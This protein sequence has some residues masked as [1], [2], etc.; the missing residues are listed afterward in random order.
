MAIL[1]V[2]SL[3]CCADK[4]IVLLAL[5]TCRHNYSVD[6]SPLK[7]A[8]QP[9]KNDQEVV[10][11]AVEKNG[12]AIFHASKERQRDRSLVLAALKQQPWIWTYL[13]KLAPE[14]ATDLNLA[15]C[16]IRQIP[17][18]FKFASEKVRHS[19][20]VTL[21][22]VTQWGEALEYTSRQLRADEEVVL[23]SVKNDGQSI[24]SLEFKSPCFNKKV[25][26]AAVR[27]CGR[28]LKWV[29]E[30]Y[31]DP[32][33]D[34]DIILAAVEQDPYILCNNHIRFKLWQL[35]QS[36]KCCIQGFKI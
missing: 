29:R 35:Y 24:R 26:L 32:N 1:Y 25:I 17:E 31:T 5:K 7:F 19:K 20:A 6:V 12:Y 28:A 3:D 4:E 11:A 9:L 10:L 33:L 27:Q 23:A 15:L 18:I 34:L 16:V 36:G 30:K 13:D 8:S 2:M 21:A 22:A 14:L